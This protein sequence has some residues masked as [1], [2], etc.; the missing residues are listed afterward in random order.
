MR[1]GYRVFHLELKHPF[2]IS[3]SSIT[4]QRT[5]IVS[6]EQDEIQGIGEATE[7]AY[8]DVSIEK[9]TTRLEQIGDKI[10][11]YKMDT[12]EDFWNYLLPLLR[13]LP[14][15]HCA[16][17][18][19]AWD[20]Y[21]KMKKMPTHRIWGLDPYA[22]L[23]VSNFTIALDDIDVMKDKIAE[24]PWPLY[25]IKLGTP[26][27]IDIIE[28]LR[29]VTDVPFRVDANAAW[30]A[31]ESIRMS[32]LLKKLNVEFIE[33]PMPADAWDEMKEVYAKSALPVI[34]DE[35]CRGLADVSRCQGRF[36]GINIKLVK[37]G[38]LTPARNMILEAKKL[39]LKTMVGCMTESSVGISAIAQLLPY[40]DYVDM[41]GALLLKRD[42]ADGVQVTEQGIEWR[43]DRSGNGVR[44]VPDA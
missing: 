8:Y 32:H 20:L 21:G 10:S 16:I 29:S 5:L 13:D 22:S 24:Q 38:G 33:Q 39:G 44:L 1:W 15:L 14:F 36:D 42:I 9:M 23:P 11:N 12:P 27:D 37:A 26:G 4:T 35:S 7:N 30:T 43:E 34:A 3:R 18:E 25:K 17:D 6:L 28:A 19:A 2:G 31:D 40:L 41:D